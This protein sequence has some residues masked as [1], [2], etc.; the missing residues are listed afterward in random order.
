MKPITQLRREKNR[1]YARNYYYR[2]RD[3]INAR[4]RAERKANPEKFRWNPVARREQATR[5]RAANPEKVKESCH[6]YE[7]NHPGRGKAWARANPDRTSKTRRN[8][9]RRLRREVLQAYGGVCA[10]CGESNIEFL[11]LDHANGDGA[12]H[13]REVGKGHG[14]YFWARRNNFP[15]DAGLRVLCH[16]CNAATHYYG[17]CPHKRTIAV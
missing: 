9:K 16:N 13:R 15:K 6:K 10:C 1:V 12:A 4:I 7:E 2:H 17:Y 5:Y 11:A 8:S 3:E 14:V